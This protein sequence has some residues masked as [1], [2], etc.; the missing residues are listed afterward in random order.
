MV[1][2]LQRIPSKETMEQIGD[3]VNRS[4][5]CVHYRRGGCGGSAGD[6][7]GKP[8]AQPDE[9]ALFSGYQELQVRGRFDP[10]VMAVV[11]LI[12]SIGKTNSAQAS[13]VAWAA[14]F[15]RHLIPG[16]PGNR[17]TA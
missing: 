7:I 6:G 9:A 15:G 17:S 13:L 14:A 1:L 3:W 8:A 5:E 10:E 4:E 16:T 11:Y 2:E 12:N